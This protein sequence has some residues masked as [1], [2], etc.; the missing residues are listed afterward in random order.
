MVTTP[1]SGPT[2][3]LSASASTGWLSRAKWMTTTDRAAVAVTVPVGL[4]DT[5]PVDCTIVD[6]AL[7][8]GASVPIGVVGLVSGDVTVVEGI[9]GSDRQLAST[10]THRRTIGRGVPR[11]PCSGTLLPQLDTSAAAQTQSAARTSA[12]ARW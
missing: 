9:D 3:V 6:V 7:G 8:A 5:R 2:W 12:R 10:S 11:R 1:G 4:A